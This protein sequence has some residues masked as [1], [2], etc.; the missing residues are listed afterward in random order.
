[1]SR[2]LMLLPAPEAEWAKLPPEEHE[3]GMRAHERFNA[4]LAEGG[5]KV[6]V[7]SPLHPSAEAVSMRPDGAGGTVV[8]DGPFTES[9]EQVVGFYLIESDDREGLEACCR[10][11][12]S[13]GDLIELRELE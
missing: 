12:A 9:V 13:T 4:E 8:T 1:M 11:L 10:Q 7:S 5:H 2:Y 6:I 3:K